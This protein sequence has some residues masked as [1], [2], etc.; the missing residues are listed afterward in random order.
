V[1]F[2]N[3]K[4]IME[5]KEIYYPRALEEKIAKYLHR[6]EI[7]CARGSRQVGK[8]T[9]L[10]HLIKD[11][12]AVYLTMD[13]WK[14]RTAFESD[15]V[16]FV[17]RYLNELKNENE[18]RAYLLLDE[19]QKAKNA[20]EGLKL[21]YD[22]DEFKNLK[23]FISSS[24]SLALDSQI[25]PQLVGRA[26]VYDLFSFDFGEYLR[27]KDAGLAKLHSERN[28][29]LRKFLN[30]EAEIIRLPLFEQ[31]FLKHWKEY[32]IFGGYPEVVKNTSEE[33]KILVL[34]NIFN[35]YVG[36]DIVEQFGI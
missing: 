16:G 25:L 13:D 35:L 11:N 18:A 20:G 3:N 33:E 31:E 2:T 14:Q 1:I 26:F 27:A 12:K 5:I 22:S 19:I 10:K 29:E 17:R 36:K 4:R 24:S 6:R 28:E 34:Q 23:L 32:A 7:V 21:I 30:G 15:P 9:I 8:T